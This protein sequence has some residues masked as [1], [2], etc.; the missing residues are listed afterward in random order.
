VSKIT[1]GCLCGALQYTIGT[2]PVLTAICH[3]T[4]CQRQ[5]GAAFSVNLGVPKG[6]LQFSK[7]TPKMFQDTGSSGL[8]VYRHFCGDCGSPIYSDVAAIPDLVFVKAG[9]LDDS[10]GVKPGVAV[11]CRSAQPWV[12]RP[13][14]VPHFDQN[15]PAA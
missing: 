8:P 14:G 11:W 15:P 3:C 4:H 12:P 6:A 13:E 5:S 10:S 7:G 2:E 1:G 9:T